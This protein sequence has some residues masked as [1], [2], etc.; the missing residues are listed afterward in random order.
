MNE[1]EQ[2]P[3]RRPPYLARVVVIACG[4]GLWFLT[5]ALISKRTPP[6]GSIDDGMHQILGGWHDWFFAHPQAANVL[7]IVSSFFIDALALF[8]L[9]RAIV[10][11]SI[12]PFIGI[13]LLFALRQLCQMLV[14]LPEP[15]QMIWHY[16]G[17]PA[18]LVTYGVATDLFFS[19]H[20][21]VAV[22]GSVELGRINWRWRIL[23]AAIAIFEMLTVLTLR[24]HYTMDVFAAL[25]AAY[26]CTHLAQVLA[27]WCDRAI[28][29][30]AGRRQADERVEV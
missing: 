19:G 18:I 25:M 16:P 11:P 17:V 9:I 14:S 29:R 28:D 6:A 23:G 10:G 1:E 4:I 2:V 15:N 30:L 8:V 26:V 21:S 20:T 12:R 3:R 7:M 27:P 24:A 5:Q 13:A 22:Y